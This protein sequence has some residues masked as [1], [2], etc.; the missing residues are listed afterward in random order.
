[1]TVTAAAYSAANSY[2]EV[3]LATENANW[4]STGGAVWR[5]TGTPTTRV[6]DG[7][8]SWWAILRAFDE[9]GNPVWNLD[10]SKIAFAVSSP[11]VTM[12]A[13]RSLSEVYGFTAADNGDQAYATLL[14]ST[15]AGTPT[16]AVTYDSVP[17]AG[18]RTGATVADPTYTDLPVPFVAGPACLPGACTYPPNTS[19]TLRTRSEVKP[20]G[21]YLDQN[22]QDKLTVYVTDKYGNPVAGAA[23]IVTPGAGLTLT[24]TDDA[25]YTGNPLLTDASGQVAV[26]GTAATP[27]AYPLQIT[28][29]GASLPDNTM[30][31]VAEPPDPDHSALDLT[32]TVTPKTD[33]I[34]AAAGESVEA[35]VTVMGSSSGNPTDGIPVQVVINE[36][37]GNGTVTWS[38]TKTCLSGDDGPGS[39][40]CSVTFTRTTAGPVVVHGYVYLDSQAVDVGHARLLPV[41]R[42][43]QTVD[44]LAGELCVVE[45]GCT[46]DPDT[47]LELQ[48]HVAVTRN[49]VGA[50]GSETAEITAYTFDKYGNPVPG[51]VYLATTETDLHLDATSITTGPDGE[52][53]ATATSSAAGDFLVTASAEAAGVPLS[54]EHGS[55]LTLTFVAGQPDATKTT[56]ALTPDTSSPAG[57]IVQASVSVIDGL[58]NPVPD[59]LVSFALDNSAAF[60]ND[61][62]ACVTDEFGACTVEFT[63]TVAELVTVSA[64]FGAFVKTAAVAFTADVP[65]LTP[66]CQ[67]AP[68]VDSAHTSRVEID[69]NNVFADG[70]STAGVFVYVFDTYGNPVVD[71]P[72]TLAPD[73][74]LTLAEA[75]LVTDADGLAA[76]TATSTVVGEW[77]VAVTVDTALF[78]TPTVTFRLGAV[79]PGVSSLAVSAPSALAG[80]P[81]TATVTARDDS[82]HPVAGVLVTFSTDS[83]TARFLAGAAPFVTITC[84]TGVDG[85]C[86]VVFTDSM[87]GTTE[88]AAQISGSA[89]SGSPQGVEFTTGAACV[90]PVCEADPGV[91]DNHRTHLAV[92]D[93]G[94]STDGGVDRV[95]VFVF[96]KYGNPVENAVVDSYDKVDPASDLVVIQPIQ[97]TNALGRSMVSYLSTVATTYQALVSVDGVEV[98]WLPQLGGF[99]G[100]RSSPV[101]LRFVDDTPPAAPVVTE[102]AANSVTADLTPVFAG[103]TEPGT[104]VVVTLS[105]GTVL[106][107]AAPT[108]TVDWSCQSSVT[109]AEG[110]L[111]IQATAADS[112][113]NKSRPTTV[114]FIVDLAPPDPPTILV[115]N[116][117]VISGLAEPNTRVTVYDEAG[118]SLGDTMTGSDGHWVLSPLPDGTT[119]GDITATATDEAGRD[120]EPAIAYLDVDLAVTITV[121]NTTVIRGTADPDAPVVVTAEDGTELGT[122]TAL[123]DGT[124]SIPTPAGAVAGPITATATDDAGNIQVA[125]GYL[126]TEPGELCVKE[127]GCEVSPH[128]PVELTTRVA[129]TA[130]D[131]LADGTDVAEITAYTYDSNGNPVVG[132]IYLT[133]DPAVTA[134]L[135]LGVTSITTD[136][137]GLGRA[138]VTSTKAGTFEVQAWADASHTTELA[139]SGSPLAVTFVAGAVCLAPACTPDASVD[140]A[141]RTRVEVTLDNQPFGSGEDQVTVYAFDKHGNPVQ[142]A[143]V[144]SSPTA[145]LSIVPPVAPTDALGVSTITYTAAAAGTYQATVA[146][147]GVDVRWVSRAN[148][149][150]STKSS[151]VALTFVGNNVCVVEAG[152]AVSPGVD[153]AHQTRVEVTKTGAAADGQDTVEIAAYT[154][155]QDGN[156]VAGVIDL[157]S[158][159]TDLHLTADFITTDA[160]GVG[161]VTAT[162]TRAGAY[163]VRAW[164][165]AAWTTELTAHGSPL[166]VAFV[167]GGVCLAPACTPD[168]SVGDTHR[169]RVE[170]TLDNQL[171]GGGGDQATVYAFDKY[172][173]PVAGAAVMSSP[174]VG[175]PAGFTVVTPITPTDAA[176]ETVITYTAAVVGAYEAT[177]TINGTDVTWVPQA[178]GDGSA[179]SSPVTLTF[180]DGSGPAVCV[181]EA[182]CA[183]TPGV[184]AAHQTRVVVTKTGATADGQDWAEITAYTFDRDG[185]P[186]AGTVDLT[187]DPADAAAGL[188]LDTASITTDGTGVGRAWVTSTKAGPYLVQAGVGGTE[189]TQSGSP[190]TVTFV[191]GAVCLAP[192]CTPDPGVDDAHRTR[193]KV[194]VDRQ[195][196]GGQDQAT[197]YA[198]DQYGNPVAGAA[199]SSSAV[200]AGLSVLAPIAPTTAQGL[201]TVSYTAGAAG[202]YEATIQINGTDVTWLPQDGSDGSAQSSPVTVTFVEASGTDVCLKEAGCQPDPGVDAAHQTRVEVTKTGATA[203]GRDTV[204]I[205]AYTFDRDGN[206]VAGTIDLT[207][208][209][210]DLKLG[211]TSITT[212]A[213]GVGRAT[214]TSVRAGAYSVK[215][216]VGGTEL[217]QSGSP[218]TVTFVAGGV[219]VA[220]ACVP[221]VSVADAHRTRVEVTA[222]QQVIGGGQDQATVYAFDQYGNPVAGAAVASAPAAGTPAGLTVVTPVAVTDATGQTVVAYTATVATTYS[223]VVTIDGAAITW[224]PQA[225]G[226][227]SAKSSPVT[228]TFTKPVC[229]MEAGCTPAPGV[230]PAHQTRVEVTVT[231]AVADGQDQAVISAYTYDEDG[232]PVAGTV[233]L[234]VQSPDL[235][236][237]AYSITTDSTGH[238][239]VTATSTQAGEYEVQAWAEGGHVNELSDH[240][241]ALTVRF[242]AGHL[243]V[244]ETGCQPAP[245]VDADHQTH[246]TV[247]KTGAV[248]DGSDRDIITAYTFDQYGNPVAGTLY[249]AA[250]DPGRLSLGAASVTTGATGQG[251][252]WATSRVAGSSV[253]TAWADQNHTVGLSAAHGSPLTLTFVA[254]SPCVSEAGCTVAP[255][256]DAAHQTRVA[257][258]R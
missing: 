148:G 209:S 4:R 143:V 150:V 135:V 196:V 92:Q 256:V 132:T 99:A 208:S 61:Q 207:G 15:T 65:C 43:P 222:D 176:G 91:D 130:T 139:E 79:S 33:P 17:V 3:G 18:L 247:T 11:A 163:T 226:N 73:A 216:A 183:P 144:T 36:E 54:T 185:H 112:S 200:D 250:A 32:P 21:A 118:N 12:S 82:G 138:T 239:T 108:G 119:S 38:Q 41:D 35:T 145:G 147:N 191:A 257:V 151:P 131:A 58:G 166:T 20:D 225:G 235:K 45:A 175:S 214:A 193:V 237:S 231:D 220:P 107:Q 213:T 219:C 258:T 14:T 165:D 224:L 1:F 42:S 255:G 241:S 50:G 124:W 232:R 16:V 31:F 59:A 22:E 161:T 28:V 52:G 19:D 206:P 186:V 95:A 170:V 102:P 57:G 87:V 72:V 142:G 117:A 236:L 34:T 104:T 109:L 75:G 194:T 101:T 177:V 203:D 98:T 164:A 121:A 44:F 105:D 195:V 66:D 29:D 126:A 153:A 81:V 246:V 63:D 201:S 240:G 13:V 157:S 254:S 88:V 48:T 120:S 227:G 51:T 74:N 192:A 94:Q 84:T 134:G 60:V 244:V 243:C 116:G 233:Y 173:N 172:G 168:P 197:V 136:A 30:H 218:L 249:F 242:L 251:T 245:G 253:V 68:G 221:D 37:D 80:A 40:A 24:T 69:P 230:T 182:G 114:G 49:N 160:T 215:A 122:T 141:H 149:D 210:A 167:A 155:D 9:Y 76:T 169:T 115:A 154:F 64:R 184:D 47:P 211:V 140:D 77:P 6:A 127:A 171:I 39:G 71:T 70:Q 25:A 97:A 86:A 223:A 55:P 26:L 110:Q 67:P 159:A 10:T 181:E 106:C 146:I 187:I 156:P 199:V 229:V 174:A 96:D 8:D 111:T 83:P 129:V 133:A 238:G 93:N 85:K 56:L 128:M 137:S 123:P 53:T 46:P 234:T 228:L 188:T 89:V 90:S 5:F 179:M 202:A 190:L 205:T 23:V 178:G 7:Q 62:S 212:D 2:V 180:T 103:T 158:A 27:G 248:A 125:S 78:D 217:A 162:S 189:L 113:G 252:V 100:D 152:C 204:E 198:F